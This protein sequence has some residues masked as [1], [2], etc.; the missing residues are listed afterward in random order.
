MMK[1][2][3]MGDCYEGTTGESGSDVEIISIVNM[4]AGWSA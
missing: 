1:M 4:L 3:K 2:M